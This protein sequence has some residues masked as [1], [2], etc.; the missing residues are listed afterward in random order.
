MYGTSSRASENQGQEK[1]M[2]LGIWNKPGTTEQRVYFNGVVDPCSYGM[3]GVKVFAVK[4]D[5]R[6]QIKFSGGRNPSAKH[7]TMDEIDRELEA[8]NNGER[9]LKWD[10]LIA[11]AS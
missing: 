4:E 2:K 9:V 6:F 1:T 3:D 8:M 10:T 11:L 5:D 7:S